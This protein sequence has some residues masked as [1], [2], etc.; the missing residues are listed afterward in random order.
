MK[1]LTAVVVHTADVI[2][3][4]DQQATAPRAEKRKLHDSGSAG[5]E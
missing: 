1:W 3:P 5:K 4:A 2:E